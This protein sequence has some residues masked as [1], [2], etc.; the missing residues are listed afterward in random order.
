VTA[1]LPA[2][3]GID[4]SVISWLLESREPAIRRLAR[5]Q[6][7]DDPSPQ[8]DAQRLEGRIVRTL[9]EGQRADGGFG[10]GPYTKWTGAHWRLVS[11]VELGIPPGEPRAVA[12]AETVLAWLTGASHRRNV[13]VIEGLARRCGSQEGNALAATS[14]LGMTDDERVRLLATSLIEWQWPDGGWNCDRRPGAHRSS[15][16]ETLPPIWG[17]HEYASATGDADA[18]AAARRGAELLLEH[19]LFRQLANG[20]P[21]ERE[22]LTPHWPPYWHYDVLQALVVLARMGLA[23]DPRAADAI[24]EVRGRQRHGRWHASM[25]WWKPPPSTRAAEAVDWRIDDSGDRMVTLRALTV[26]RTAG[27]GD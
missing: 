17:L 3:G 11:L 4:S 16:H 8:D 19:R 13:P 10:V 2:E 24:E 26:L 15:F 23:G 27:K 9:L 20:E 7:L 6:L 1:T 25:R 5:R 12:A 14:R 18:A 21:I 22:W